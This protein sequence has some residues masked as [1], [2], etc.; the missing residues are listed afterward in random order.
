MG[1]IVPRPGAV[2]AGPAGL[3]NDPR[4]RPMSL[5]D[6]TFPNPRSLWRG[7]TAPGTGARDLL[8]FLVVL[9]AACLMMQAL[10]VSARRA[11][12]PG[13][14]HLRPAPMPAVLAGPLDEA[15]PHQH[16]D[17]SLPFDGRLRS[18]PDPA[19]HSDVEYHRHAAATSGVVT[20]AEDGAAPGIA[21]WAAMLR[22]ALD[23]PA[24]PTL[25]VALTLELTQGLWAARAS[26]AF[27][28][29]GTAPP[30]RPP[31]R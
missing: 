17:T 26:A 1:V 21:A 11:M 24:L 6:P 15:L 2:R 22:S 23:L 5:A 10:A 8:R 16:D 7:A 25:A 30:L 20:V 12:G 3:W 9:L 27:A 14:Y 13:H 19:F 28:T 31:R 18:H 29:R 4:L